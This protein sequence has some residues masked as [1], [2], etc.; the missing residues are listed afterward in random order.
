MCLEVSPELAPEIPEARPESAAVIVLVVCT[1][2]IHFT[3]AKA[4]S[5]Q[6]RA[7]SKP[8]PVAGDSEYES[9]GDEVF[10]VAIAVKFV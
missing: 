7:E 8:A 10:P 4:F 6:E 9:L 1:R 2:R 3:S 5:E